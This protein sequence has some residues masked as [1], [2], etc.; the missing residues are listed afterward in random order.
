M[1]CETPS[2]CALASAIADFAIEFASTPCSV[3][4]AV[5][6]FSTLQIRVARPA[7][8]HFSSIGF[9]ACSRLSSSC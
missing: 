1:N 3:R 6:D 4:L 2:S 7:Y 5:G 9:C 8:A